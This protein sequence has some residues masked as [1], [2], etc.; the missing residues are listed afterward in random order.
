[1]TNNQVKAQLKKRNHLILIIGGFGSLLASYT[2]VSVSLS[3]DYL[4]VATL[5]LGGVFG[6]AG[7]TCLI[8]LFCSENLLFEEGNLKI[9]SIN[10]KIKNEISV[11][12]IES[13]SEIEKSNKYYRWKDLTIYTKD[14]KYTVS[15]TSFS[16]Y[17]SLRKILTKGKKRNSFAEK[18]WHYKIN[19]RYGIGFSIFGIM[20]LL[21]FGSMYLKKDIEIS[22]DQL[23]TIEGTVTDNLKFRKRRKSR[24][25]LIEIKLEEYPKFKFKLGGIKLKATSVNKLISNVQKGNKLKIEI[26]KHQLQKKFTKEI[27]M[28]FWDKSFNYRIIN[29]YGL[30]DEKS[31]YFNLNQFNK[32]RKE[33]RNSWQ[34]F[35]LLGLSLCFLG[36]GVY[37]L[38][39]NKKPKMN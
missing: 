13:Y 4:Q 22:S 10:G 34:M 37:E 21:L 12:N 18:L 8:T 15:S 33:D 23:A 6:L 16:N 27:P 32:Y 7:I 9:I 5:I 36:Y 28:N 1:M 11:D 25:R 2:L 26:L 20:L 14:S 19:R 29:I 24:S 31:N 38:R 39:K 17:E 30:K 3:D 35:F